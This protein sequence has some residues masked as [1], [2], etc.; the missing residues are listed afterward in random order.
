MSGV[1]RAFAIGF[2]MVIASSSLFADDITAYGNG[3]TEA[4][5]IRDA[6]AMLAQHIAINTSS[7]T[8]IIQSDDGNNAVDYMSINAISSYDID[9]LGTELETERL[10]DGSWTARKTI[11]ESSLGLYIEK[12]EKSAEIINSLYEKVEESDTIS[13]SDYSR[14]L[15]QLKDYETNRIIIYLL[16][17]SASISPVRTN[18]TD[19]EAY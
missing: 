11:P 7:V 14:L 17:S 4:E 18:S 15:S 2:L 9:F 5:A 13:F 6:D 8:N 19:I 12:V 16:D 3:R 10:E 1:F